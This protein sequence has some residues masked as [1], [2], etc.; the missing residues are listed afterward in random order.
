MKIGVCY[1]HQLRRLKLRSRAETFIYPASEPT[2]APISL[3]EHEHTV[4]CV[5]KTGLPLSVQVQE[6]PWWSGVGGKMRASYGK[7]GKLVEV[8][9]LVH[10]GSLKK[11][12]LWSF[13]A[14][15]RVRPLLSLL[16]SLCIICHYYCHFC[17]GLL[18]LL[19]GV[20]RST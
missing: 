10:C 3:Q 1:S 18:S 6:C 9:R 5:Y 19:S 7:G 13:S 2:S 4:R 16:L 8:F 17:L 14:G 12:A 11:G 15:N 20:A